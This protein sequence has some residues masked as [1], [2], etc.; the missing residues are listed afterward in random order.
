MLYASDDWR[1]DQQQ[2]EGSRTSRH[3]DGV[4]VQ[5]LEGEVALEGL[6]LA[7]ATPDAQNEGDL[8]LGEVQEVLGNVDRQLHRGNT[9]DQYAAQT[10]DD[11]LNMITH[12]QTQCNIGSFCTVNTQSAHSKVC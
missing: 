12:R 3:D 6:A 8:D 5:L 10:H 11:K 9:R 1:R 7:L 2:A 4:D